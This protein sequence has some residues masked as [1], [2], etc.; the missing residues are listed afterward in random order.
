MPTEGT[1]CCACLLSPYRACG[2]PAL[3]TPPGSYPVPLFSLPEV[4]LLSETPSL[5]S[6]IGHGI[7][8]SEFPLSP[9]MCAL[10]S[11]LL[12]SLNEQNLHA[13]NQE[14]YGPLSLYLHLVCLHMLLCKWLDINRMCQMHFYPSFIQVLIRKNTRSRRFDRYFCTLRQL[15]RKLA[16]PSHVVGNLPFFTSVPSPSTIE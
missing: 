8:M 9:A 14:L 11:L 15:A 2:V 5:S 1:H 4:S 3:S 6:Q 10:C 16:K 13:P 12:M 7:S